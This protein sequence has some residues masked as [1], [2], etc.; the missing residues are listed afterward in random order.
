MPST[1]GSP[2][3]GDD[4]A[5]EAEAALFELFEALPELAMTAPPAGFADRVL[6]RA[7]LQTAAARADL[8]AWRPLRIVLALC[9]V[10]TGLG[11]LW[12]PPVLAALAGFWSF[13]GL[14]RGGG[15]GD[16]R[17]RALGWPRSCASGT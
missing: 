15:A 4:Q 17:G 3:S 7:G 10:A 14:V 6:V 9:L 13:S 5:E 12:L 8:F 2:P 16:D 11:A 1:A